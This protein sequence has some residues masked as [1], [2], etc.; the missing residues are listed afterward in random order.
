MLKFLPGTGRGTARSGVEGA[1]R[2]GDDRG[3]HA[4]RVLQNLV[5]GHAK[6]AIAS[7]GEEGE[8]SVVPLRAVP[9]VV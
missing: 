3:S 1:L 2:I 6:H 5:G 7:V 8:A 4:V 9:K